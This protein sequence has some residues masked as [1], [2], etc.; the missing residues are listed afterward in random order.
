MR[1]NN[2]L[3]YTNGEYKT[4]QHY[5]LTRNINY[6]AINFLIHL[7]VIP[8]T[9]VLILEMVGINLA[10]MNWFI[11]IYA[12]QIRYDLNLIDDTITQYF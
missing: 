10:S 12:E 5:D 2:K 1:H 11:V 3:R 8:L 9:N 7:P 4:R 6:T